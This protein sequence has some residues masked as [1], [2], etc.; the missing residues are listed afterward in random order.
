MH[1]L[2]QQPYEAGIIIIPIGSRTHSSHT[3]VVWIFRAAKRKDRKCQNI[4]RHWGK[5]HTHKPIYTHTQTHTHTEFRPA[6]SAQTQAPSWSLSGASLSASSPSYKVKKSEITL[7]L[8]KYP[9][10]ATKLG[11]TLIGQRPSKCG[12][13]RIAGMHF[14]LPFRKCAL[15]GLHM[16]ALREM[17]ESHFKCFLPAGQHLPTGHLPPQEPHSGSL[18]VPSQSAPCQAQESREQLW[19]RWTE[20]WLVPAN[21]P[22]PLSTDKQNTW[23]LAEALSLQSLG[24]TQD[25]N[26]QGT[27][28]QERMAN[29]GAETPCMHVSFLIW[30]AGILKSPLHQNRYHLLSTSTALNTF[31]S[32]LKE[33]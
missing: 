15:P 27:F 1:H 18:A 21:S 17:P 32:Y 8:Q 11:N 16:N 13:L 9:W 29:Q 22:S 2:W 24:R 30:K 5:T 20:M 4:S 7:P 12:L 25:S 28:E 33:P 3:W 6:I 14:H 19:S 31:A 23:S 10:R 26:R